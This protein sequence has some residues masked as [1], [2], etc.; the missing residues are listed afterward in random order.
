MGL[1]PALLGLTASIGLLIK[2][3]VIK[4]YF[5][6]IHIACGLCNFQTLEVV[7]GEDWTEV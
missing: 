6:I 4:L 5:L 3:L 1:G 2:V 7:D